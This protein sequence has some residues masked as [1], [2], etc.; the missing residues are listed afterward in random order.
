M[1]YLSAAPPYAGG[2]SAYQKKPN[3]LLRGLIVA[4][5]GL[6]ALLYLHITGIYNSHN[7]SM[8]ELSLREDSTLPQRAI[9]RP[10]PRPPNKPQPQE[11]IKTV[12]TR[13]PPPLIK[14]VQKLPAPADLPSGI[15]ESISDASETQAQLTQSLAWVP[16]ALPKLS[17]ETFDSPNSYFEMVRFRI[18]KNKRYPETAKKKNLRGRVIISM[19][20]TLHGKVESIA[21]KKS[22]GYDIL[23]HAAMA[24]VERAV[25]FPAPPARFFKRDIL[26]NIPIL[27]EIT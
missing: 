11:A 9:P 7:V 16:A 4:S 24:A 25:P 18:E 1:K 13:I 21:V 22:S 26:L 19:L 8:I 2:Q 27:F 20:I 23:D 10:R 6:H 14:P 3:F 12:T 17:L 15:T 5:I